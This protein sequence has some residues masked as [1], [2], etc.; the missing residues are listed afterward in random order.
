L[1]ASFGENAHRSL[2]RNVNVLVVDAPGAGEARVLLASE[3]GEV[4]RSSGL[5]GGA[6][7]LRFFD[8]STCV[9]SS[10]AAPMLSAIPATMIAA[11]AARPRRLMSLRSGTRRPP[12]EP[13]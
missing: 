5:Q 13:P 8:I 6:F 1:A 2:D 12:G 10:A 9:A 3:G 11:P 4:L 7:D